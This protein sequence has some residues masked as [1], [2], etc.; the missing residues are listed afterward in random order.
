MLKDEL[1][2]D[3]VTAIARFKCRSTKNI[4]YFRDTIEMST[5]ENI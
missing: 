3:V 4:E 2:I 5:S 1:K